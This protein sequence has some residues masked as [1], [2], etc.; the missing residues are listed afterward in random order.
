MDVML[1]RTLSGSAVPALM[2]HARSS[3]LASEVYGGH[4]NESTC[5][6]SGSKF[7]WSCAAR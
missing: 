2:V 7:Y 1:V 4:L 3:P 6:R 5:A